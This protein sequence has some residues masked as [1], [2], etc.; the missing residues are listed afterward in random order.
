MIGN[1]LDG[2]DYSLIAVLA[3]MILMIVLTLFGVI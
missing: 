2:F 1:K 3:V